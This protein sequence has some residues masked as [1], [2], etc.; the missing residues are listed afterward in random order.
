M[1]DKKIF[2]KACCIFFAFLTLN[3]SLYGQEAYRIEL[4]VRGMDKEPVILG[5]FYGESTYVSDTSNYEDGVHVFSGSEPLPR[6][7]YFIARDS[8]RLLDLVVN[9]DQKF[10]L[11]TDTSD[12]IM[13]LVVTGDTDNQLFLEDMKFNAMRNQEAAPFL[14]VLR[15]STASPEARASAQAGL[16][17]IN[18]A[19]RAHQ[20]DVIREHPN[21][22]MAKIYRA[23]RRERLPEAEAE[24][25]P[26]RAFRYYKEHYWDNFDLSDPVM[27][28]LNQP[29]FKDKLETYFDNLVVHQS[30]SIIA[31]MDRLAKVASENEDTYKYFVWYLTIKYREPRIMGL[32]EIFVHMNDAYFASGEMDYW[33]NAQLRKNIQDYADRLRNSLIGKKAPEMI[34]QDENME[35]KSLYDIDSKYTIIYFFDPDC[36]HC[37]LATPVLN[38]LY[39]SDKFDMEVF[40]V[41]TDTSM[42]KMKDYIRDMGLSWV[43]VNGPRTFTRP[44]YELYDAL[45]TPTFYI[46]DADKTII[47]KKL[48]VDRIEEFLTRY[49]EGKK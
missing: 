45:T 24:Q 43:T 10:R 48:P 3:V 36:H 29:M 21:S 13:N 1:K 8:R 20:E 31:E 12:Y 30:D 15:D 14:S 7:M 44:Y 34:M 33:A 6:G 37:K 23:Q 25:N 16:N 26:E 17:A 11:S 41:S 35:K 22:F 32:D 5:T 42:V 19:V 38:D 28:R 18:D 9:E 40:A 46:L 39:D 49:E 27:L 47:A 2:L 4:D